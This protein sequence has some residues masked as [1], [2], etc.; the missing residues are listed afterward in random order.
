MDEH[1][2]NQINPYYDCF[3]IL[4]V[5]SCSNV[6]IQYKFVTWQKCLFEKIQSKRNDRKNPQNISHFMSCIVIIQLI[7]GIA[8]GINLLF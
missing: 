5:G 1:N 3:E 2:L 7:R 4:Y 8:C 6:L